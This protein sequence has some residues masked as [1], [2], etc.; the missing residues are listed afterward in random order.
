VAETFSRLLKALHGQHGPQD[1][2]QAYLYRIAHNWIVDLFRSHE[3]TFELNDAL[4]CDELPEEEAARQIRQKQV[5]R[6]IRR[7]TPDQQIVI[8]LKYLECWSNEEIARVLRKPVG[9][10]KSIQHRALVSLHTLLAES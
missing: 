6:A 1:H 3:Q 5:R 10:V 8:T 2:L 4:P 7:L 9:A